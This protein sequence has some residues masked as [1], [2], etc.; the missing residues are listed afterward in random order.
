MTTSAAWAVYAPIPEQEQGKEFSASV[1]GG[2][3]HD[4][5]IFGAANGAISS[6]VY[7]FE[8][9]LKFNSSLTDQTFFSASYRLTIDHFSDRPGDKT[10]D[11]H[12]FN[13]RLAHAFS[14]A[15]NI[16]ISDNY[17][18]AKNPESLLAGIPVNTD[19]SNKRNQLDG[20]LVTNVNEQTN[21]TAKFRSIHYR[22]DNDT[23]GDSLDRTENLYGLAF[24]YDVVPE[25]KAIGEFR[26]QDVNYRSAGGN[27][28]KM[29]NFLIGGLDYAV[30]HKLSAT[31]RLGYEWRE[32][33]GAGDT[34]APY[35]E[36]SAKLDFAEKSYLTGGYIHTLEEASNVAQ[37]TDVKVNRFFVNIQ[38]AV[39]AFIVV[40]S[41]ITYEPSTLLGRGAQ[42]DVEEDTTRFGLALSY[43]PTQH[44]SVSATFDNDRVK[45]DD[46]ARALK[47]QRY[48]ISA[49]YSF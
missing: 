49:A 15:T 2:F 42:V 6:T 23:L 13:V 44:W 46:P 29:S 5:N 1:R 43:L 9:T 18:I 8:P 21:A 26:R 38:H 41:S 31:G 47:R 28:D 12:D 45:S 25:M 3:A 24:S 10:L 11:S 37:F 4:S 17:T 7:S 14:E 16:D 30:A 20:R 40:S 27:K 34:T 36:L 35:V 39:S 32:R 22:Y 19:Q 48:G 33:E